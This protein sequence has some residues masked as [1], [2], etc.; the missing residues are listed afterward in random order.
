MKGYFVTLIR[1]SMQNHASYGWMY[2]SE[3]ITKSASQGHP[4]TSHIAFLTRQ[5]RL[6]CKV[7]RWVPVTLQKPT[8]LQ[9]HGKKCKNFETRHHCYP[10]E[11]KYK[12]S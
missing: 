2:Q 4:R 3:T 8:N 5:K 9:L 10:G 12:A 7:D 11:T 1:M 6:D